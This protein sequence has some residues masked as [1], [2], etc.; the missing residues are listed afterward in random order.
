MENV[1]HQRSGSIA[2]ETGDHAG[3]DSNSKSQEATINHSNKER[4]RKSRENSESDVSVAIVNRGQQHGH[5]HGDNKAD[6]R[7]HPKT[8]QHVNAF[9]EAGPN[10]GTINGEPVRERADKAGASR[11]SAKAAKSSKRQQNGN[12]RN[13]TAYE[14]NNNDVAD[15]KTRPKRT[16]DKR[17]V[18]LYTASVGWYDAVYVLLFLGTF[19]LHVGS[20]LT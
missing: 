15:E 2:A 10:L 6:L 1:A 17:F 20:F 5:H 19:C 12:A 14:R 18:E 16:H 8:S 13:A 7:G 9:K 3:R 11:S 4:G